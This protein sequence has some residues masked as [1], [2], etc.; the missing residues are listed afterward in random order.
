MAIRDQE[1]QAA[2]AGAPSLADRLGQS[3]VELR[4][5]LETSR[6]V[7]RGE[8][9]YILIDPLNFASHRF[10]RADYAILTR[11]SVE[12][13]LCQIFEGLVA[14][15]ELQQEDSER[16][17]GFIYSL[18]KIGFLNL[19]ISDEK[20]LYERHNAKL[21]SKKTNTLKTALFFQVPLWQPDS[22]LT[23]TTRFAKPFL[24]VPLFPFGSRWLF[25]PP[26]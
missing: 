8:V 21:A 9:C 10:S 7:F 2:A 16:F 14:S 17:Y 6:H 1:P 12:Q 25:W 23:R 22:F 20:S 26:G 13:P 4:A 11:V 18:H 5:D 15:G 24:H 19:P 3:C